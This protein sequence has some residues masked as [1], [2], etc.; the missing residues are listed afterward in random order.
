MACPQVAGVIALMYASMCQNMI[1]DYK[2]D[3]ENFALNIRQYL[4]NGA[5]NIPSLAGLLA[6]GRLNALEAIENIYGNNST[7]SGP[8]LICTSGTFTVNNP[9]G[10][11]VSW[12]ES[13]NLTE[14]PTGTFTANGSG[15]GWVEATLITDCGSV[16]LPRKPF[17]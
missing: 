7:I 13:S 17:G 5:D 16:T 15:S 11:T 1:L 9:S 8:S 10:A 4:L 14:S 6:H 3:P 12:N 2:S